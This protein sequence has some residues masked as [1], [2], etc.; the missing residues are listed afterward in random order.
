MPAGCIGVALEWH[1]AVRRVVDLTDA[2][3]ST[4]FGPALESVEEPSLRSDSI[5]SS[6]GSQ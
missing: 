5:S 6:Y 2:P 1:N 3:K 4:F